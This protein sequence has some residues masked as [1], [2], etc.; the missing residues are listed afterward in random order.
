MTNKGFKIALQDSITREN[1]RVLMT[2][3]YEKALLHEELAPFFVVELGDDIESKEWVEHIELL[4]DFWLAKL[5]DEPTYGGNFIGAHLNVP[6]IK[7]ESF[8]HWIELFSVSVDEVYVP[9]IANEFKKQGREM[10]K[11]F[12][13]HLKI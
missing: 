12:I 13:K 10:S 2:N 4:A 11:E 6:S 7:R 8:A 9:S 5:L 1:L 3:F